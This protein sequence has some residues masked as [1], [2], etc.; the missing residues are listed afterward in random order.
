M[1]HAAAYE[2][3]RQCHAEKGWG[4]RWLCR[5]ASIARV[6]YYQWLK[7]DVPEEEKE[8]EIIVQLIQEYDERF[9]HILGYRR[10][11]DWINRLNHTHYSRTVS[12]GS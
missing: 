1:R 7:R 8:N 9:H 5:Q 12:T 11:T 2:A 10:M 3:I 4:I 6:S